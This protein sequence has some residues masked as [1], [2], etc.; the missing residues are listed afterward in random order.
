MELLLEHL[1]HGLMLSLLL[2][3]P[4]VL[5]A[6]AIGLVVGILQAVT[7]VQEQTIAAAPKI[8]GVF[9]IILL[10]GGLMMSMTSDYVRESFHIAFNE[11]PQDGLF[12]LPPLTSQASGQAR[13]RKFFDLQSKQGMQ[14]EKFKQYAAQWGSSEGGNDNATVLKT[15]RRA[16][17]GNALAPSE[18]LMLD[19][20][21]GH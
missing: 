15:V 7:Q 11:I 12:I 17:Q 8:V 10:G 16:G 3:L 4:S 19:K 2:S 18:K 5:T 9:A 20:Q 6:A 14:S 13:A 21:K 1:G